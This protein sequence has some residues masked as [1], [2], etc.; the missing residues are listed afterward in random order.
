MPDKPES[1]IIAQNVLALI[2][3][4]CDEGGLPLTNEHQRQIIKSA[5]ANAIEDY[6]FDEIEMIIQARL[7]QHQS[8]L[9][10]IEIASLRATMPSEE[11]RAG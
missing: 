2:V 5:I 6:H 7:E 8:E 4:R 9:C 3:S 10:E 1:I 11:A